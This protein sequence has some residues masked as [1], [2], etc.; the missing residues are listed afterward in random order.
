MERHIPE[1]IK[2][3]SQHFFT[4]GDIND[5]TSSLDDVTF[6]DFSKES[7]SELFGTY[8][9]IVTQNDDTD[10][11]GFQVKGHTSDTRGE[12]NHFT[13]LDLGKTENS[14][15]TITDGDN[16]TEFLDVVLRRGKNMP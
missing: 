5:G 7:K 11:V 12:L 13:G 3:S 9:P 1:S 4:D 16:G 14:G 15:N 10:V 6:L 8:S 2:D